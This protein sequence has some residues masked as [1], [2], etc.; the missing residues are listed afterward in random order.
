MQ[1]KICDRNLKNMYI[2]DN[3]DEILGMVIKAMENGG[4]GAFDTMVAVCE[5]SALLDNVNS[6]NYAEIYREYL[7]EARYEKNDFRKFCKRIKDLLV[8]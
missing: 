2:F 8:K 5:M 7:R 4:Y 6:E 3:R 1:T